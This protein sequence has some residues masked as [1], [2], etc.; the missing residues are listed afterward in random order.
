M[1]RRNRRH[2]SATLPATK[3]AFT[4]PEKDTPK[5]LELSAATSSR[6]S[7]I[8]RYVTRALVI[9]ALLYAFLA[10]FHTIYDV[11]M[12]WQ[13]AGGRWAVQH[14]Y[15]PSTDVLSYTAHG[16]PWIYP[17]LSGVMFYCIYSLGGF[18]ALTWFTAIASMLTVLLLT[19]QSGIATG[20][21]AII[22]VPVLAARITVRAD[23]FST[24]LFAAELSILWIYYRTGKGIIWLLPFLTLLWVNLHWG[25]VT[26]LG[27]IGAYLMLESS[28]FLSAK[29]RVVAKR[30]LREVWL[31]LV[32]SCAATLVNPW[33]PALYREMVRWTTDFASSQS[34]AIAEFAPLRISWTALQGAVLWRNPDDSAIWWLLVAAFLATIIALAWRNPGAALLIAGSAIPAIER[35]RF[36]PMFASVVV[37]VGGSVLSDA[38]TK[39]NKD[40]DKIGDVSLAVAIGV[41][42]CFVG[43]AGLRAYD[44]ISNRYYFNYQA[45]DFGTGL[46][47]WYPERAMSFAEREHLPGNIFNGYELGGFLAWRLPEYPDFIDSR[48][49]PFP[50]DVRTADSELP[51]EE[52]DSAAWQEASSKWGFQTAIVPV[53]RIDGWDYFPKLREFCESKT[54]RPV[55]LDEVSAIF[56]RRGPATQ[57]LIDEF[58]IDCKTVRLSPPH[59]DSSSRKGRS[60]LFNF[61][62]NAAFLLA[63]LDRPKEAIEALDVA[64]RIYPDSS[65]LHLQ[66]GHALMRLGRLNDAERELRRSIQLEPEVVSWEMLSDLLWSE[67]RHE[68]SVV[69]L[70]KAAEMALQPQQLYLKIA[71]RE[72][73]LQHGKEALAAF[74]QAV[75]FAVDLDTSTSAASEFCAQIAEG[76]ARVYFAMGDTQRAI[77]FQE[78]ALRFTPGDIRR[79]KEIAGL[80]H[81]LG[82][83]AD[84]QEAMRHAQQEPV[85]HSNY[86]T[87]Q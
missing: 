86:T 85:V 53:G 21:L 18:S 43:L 46:S 35:Y 8:Y 5:A 76:R 11:D 27:L 77:A 26:S 44:L 59:A 31:W 34:A 50:R 45:A 24:V 1:T 71:Q 67:Q 42:S 10:G 65:H 55:Y 19:R 68:E 52:P 84:A 3:T 48:G 81:A 66:S 87:H 49:R 64:Q 36:Q 47:W 12:G 30:R 25:F 39:H 15:V 37:I 54:W 70:R 17:P 83:D 61:W 23:L 62:T 33:G 40:T 29:R 32:A 74:D 80:Y 14:H 28:E 13:L 72:T 60:D 41:C 73:Q 79:W 16:N 78:Q 38:A 51:L 75:K 63:M 2:S 57:A 9:S 82:R 58:Q 56:L 22:A 69:E 7:V 20:I 6:Y 4:Q